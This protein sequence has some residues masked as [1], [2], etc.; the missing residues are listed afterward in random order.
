MFFL[1]IFEILKKIDFQI[2]NKICRTLINL[3]LNPKLYATT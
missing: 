2:I 1:V 3:R